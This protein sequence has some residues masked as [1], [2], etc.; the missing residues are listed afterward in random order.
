MQR[1]AGS[2]WRWL[3]EDG[4]Q[5]PDTIQTPYWSVHQPPR[6]RRAP[7]AP[8]AASPMPRLRSR[9]QLARRAQRGLTG[10]GAVCLHRRPRSHQ[11]ARPAGRLGGRRP[12]QAAAVGAESRAACGWGT[13][14]ATT[15]VAQGLSPEPRPPRKTLVR[16]GRVRNAGRRQE[17]WVQD[18]KPTDGRQPRVSHPPTPPRVQPGP[19]AVPGAP[20]LAQCGQYCQLLR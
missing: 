12:D 18:A 15:A 2:G 7:L 17:L 5:T 11:V 3:A 14:R 10:P 13:T 6:E 9:R 8:P 4:R 1:A 16:A 19:P 20:L